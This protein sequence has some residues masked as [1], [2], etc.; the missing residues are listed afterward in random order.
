M[1]EEEDFLKQYL[2][3]QSVSL[4]KKNQIQE[5]AQFLQQ[6]FAQLGAATSRILT[7]A[8]TNPA[9]FAEF[10]SHV[11]GAR[12]IL[13][14]NHYDVQPAE[15]LDLWH[16][17]PFTLTEQDGTLY[18]RGIGDDKGELAA[19]LAAL[20]R[21]RQNGQLPLNVKFL[22]EGAEEQ[23]SPNLE[24]LLKQYQDLLGADFCLWES[25]GK[26]AAGHMEISLGCKGG[27]AFQLTCH[28]AEHDLHS[29]LGAIAENPAWRLV[30]ALASLKNKDDEITLPGLMDDVVPLTETQEKIAAAGHF[31]YTAFAKSY[32]ISRP[33]TVADA[34][35]ALLTRP[36]MTINGLSSG[37]EGPGIGKTILPH[38][39]SAKLDCRLVPNQTPAKMIALIKKA[40]INNGFPDVTVSEHYLGE[41]PFRTDPDD[42]LV[43]TAI[44]EAKAAYGEV[45]I[46]LNSA[47]S[48]PQKYFYDVNHAPIISMGI[49]NA[50]SAAH[51]PNEN[52]TIA[53]YNQFVDYLTKLLP[54][55]A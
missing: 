39:A 31:D 16:S 29:S 17:D 7:T 26:N 9:V 1:F 48:G 3:F 50:N 35:M 12:T 36:T 52:V 32:G 47:G 6:H 54:Q 11:P 13:F 38:E 5:T 34:N 51:G 24:V 30:Q 4:H 53:D 10:P 2:Q 15:P 37:Y 42:P 19:R 23:G 43:Q 45:D 33:A 41:P 28:F 22:V 25:G 49:N 14:Y 27:V 55:L 21:L 46:E 44:K 18:A 8:V 40:L 20:A